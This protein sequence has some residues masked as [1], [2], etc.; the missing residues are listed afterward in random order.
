M[1]SSVKN[2]MSSIGDGTK[3][4]GCGTADLAQRFGDRT[5]EIARR[6]G[7]RRAVIGLAILGVAVAG[8]IVLVRYL[9]ARDEEELED[10]SELGPDDVRPEPRRRSK[11]KHHARVTNERAS[12]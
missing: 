1:L 11:A 5:V 12:H 10:L 7:P 6:V 3:R 9:R 8:S 2:V 4:F